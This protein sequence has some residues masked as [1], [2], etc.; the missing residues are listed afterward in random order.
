[1]PTKQPP[2][3]KTI[4]K[5]Y[6]EENEDLRNPKKAKVP[7]AKKESPDKGEADARKTPKRGP[8]RT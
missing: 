3:K 5:V 1:M 7:P 6:F 8:K 4:T 2:K